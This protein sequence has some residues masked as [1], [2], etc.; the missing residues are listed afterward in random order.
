[1]VRISTVFSLLLVDEGFRSTGPFPGG[2]IQQ[3]GTAQGLVMAVGS[4]AATMSSVGAVVHVVPTSIGVKSGHP[5]FPAAVE[6]TNQMGSIGGREGL[7]IF[8]LGDQVWLCP[9]G[10]SI[11]EAWYS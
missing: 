8:A 9:G 10:M 6:A 7:E 3:G 5:A 1:M 11:D 2:T 4:A